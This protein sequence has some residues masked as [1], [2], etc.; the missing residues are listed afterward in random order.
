[1][2]VVTDA[3]SVLVTV[4]N[5]DEIYP[6]GLNGYI[7]DVP[8]STFCSDGLLTRVGFMTP[9]DVQ[10]FTE[11]L[12]AAGLRFQAAED[13]HVGIVDQITG[14]TYYWEW[15]ETTVI[16]GGIRLA[17]VTGDDQEWIATPDSW[18]PEESLDLAQGFVPESDLGRSVH[19]VGELEEDLE[20]FYDE[21]EGRFGFHGRAFG[22]DP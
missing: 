7:R 8:N 2:A 14:A 3:L 21:N 4:E 11:R 22:F 6:G 10:I 12:M 19:A 16:S 13:S 5:L 15:F 17:R 18:T 9:V 20:L 1:M